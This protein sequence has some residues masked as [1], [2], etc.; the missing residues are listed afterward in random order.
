MELEGF[1]NYS[2]L[3]HC[4]VYALV[5]RKEVVYIGQSKSIGERLRTH[6]RQRKGGS[7]KV[8]FAKRVM[9]G[10][11]FDEIWVQACMLGE[12]DTLEAAM[13]KKYQPKFNVRHMPP[14]PSIDLQMLI[15]M[16]PS[17]CLTP[18]PEPRQNASWRRL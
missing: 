18:Q 5:K 7:R 10:I 8:G 17:P 15:E 11:A 1:V 14:K 9:V 13:I 12:L 3:L 2:A 6:W 4:G 16:M